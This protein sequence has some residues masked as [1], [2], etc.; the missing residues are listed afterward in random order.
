MPNHNPDLP[1]MLPDDSL[2]HSHPIRFIRGLFIPSQP[3]EV[4]TFFKQVD[5]M[6]AVAK[7]DKLDEWQFI[8]WI[9][10]LTYYFA[11]SPA[12]VHGLIQRGASLD[13][14]L[15]QMYEEEVGSA[16]DNYIALT[17]LETYK[18]H[19]HEIPLSGNSSSDTG[20]LFLPYAQRNGEIIRAAGKKDE[21]AVI[22]LLNDSIITMSRYRALAPLLEKQ[23]LT[24]AL[25][26]LGEKLDPLIEGETRRQ[27]LMVFEQPAVPYDRDSHRHEYGLRQ[28][29]PD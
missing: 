7:V 11:P 10:P 16:R 22:D 29:S 25:Q 23:H 14:G 17:A 13:F 28:R 21:K 12:T 2:Y 1:R 6:M 3:H 19:G 26:L 9:Q 8:N 20:D 24:K 15:K 27:T 18:C 5:A 4:E